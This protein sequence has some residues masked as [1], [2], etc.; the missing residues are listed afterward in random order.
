MKLMSTRRFHVY[1]EQDNEPGLFAARCL[2]M[3]V[4]SQGRTEQEALKNIRA[5]IGLHVDTLENELKGKKLVE[6]EL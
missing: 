5:A 2:E 3:S 4:F 1:V 6:V